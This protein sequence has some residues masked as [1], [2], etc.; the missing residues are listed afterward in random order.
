MLKGIAKDKRVSKK[1]SIALYFLDD[2]M[3][4]PM[5]VADYKNAVEIVVLIIV[6]L[7]AFFVNSVKEKA[8]RAIKNVSETNETSAISKTKNRENDDI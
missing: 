4:K 1:H 3:L 8:I 5:P 6:R 7:A 2:A